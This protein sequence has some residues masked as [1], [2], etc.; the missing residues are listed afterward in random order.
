MTIR[1]VAGS[2]YDTTIRPHLPRKVGD[3]DGVALRRPRL[4]DIDTSV[5]GHEIPLRE[6]IREHVQQGDT[7]VLIGAGHGVSIVEAAQCVGDSGKVFGYEAS[8]EL[9]AQA[10]ETTRLNDVHGIASVATAAVGHVRSHYGDTVSDVVLSPTDL[11]HSDVLVMDCEGAEMD[12][13]EEMEWRPRTIIVETHGVFD[14]PTDE[15]ADRLEEMGY[16]IVSS[17][18][19][20]EEE[21][22]FILAAISKERH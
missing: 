14:S 10:T 12:V 3:A 21:D 5:P 11:P 15:V 9:A 19:E 13:L 7:V 22:V 17:V 1:D 8:P 2:V 16:D 20:K 4:L 6:A 18:A